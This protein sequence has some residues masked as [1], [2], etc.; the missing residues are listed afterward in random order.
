MYFRAYIVDPSLSTNGQPIGGMKGFLK[1]LNKLCRGC[2][3]P[4]HSKC[5]TPYPISSFF[6]LSGSLL[7]LI[8]MLLIQRSN[9][10]KASRAS[11][12]DDHF[13]TSRGIAPPFSEPS[14]RVIRGRAA[15]PPLTHKTQIP[16]SISRRFQGNCVSQM[17]QSASKG[18]AKTVSKTHAM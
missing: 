7:S 16:K 17:Y 1:I 9:Q 5:H 6:Q 15:P 14:Q 18:R 3:Y 10:A 2:R 8:S 13:Q 12:L 4:N 11:N